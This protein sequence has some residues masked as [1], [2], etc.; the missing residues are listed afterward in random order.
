[1]CAFSL[2][3][4]KTYMHFLIIMHST[5]T[6]IKNM[7]FHIIIHTINKNGKS[8]HYIFAFS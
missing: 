5:K 6:K 1:M 3:K 2:N 8:M 4:K 7:H